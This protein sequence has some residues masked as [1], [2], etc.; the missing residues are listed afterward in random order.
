MTL[1]WVKALDLGRK[2]CCIC[3]QAITMHAF[4][5]VMYNKKRSSGIVENTQ[6][7]V[8]SV[9]VQTRGVQSTLALS[10]PG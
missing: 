5:G 10:T 2:S 3:H 7:H 1:G 4:M 6:L 8:C 9:L